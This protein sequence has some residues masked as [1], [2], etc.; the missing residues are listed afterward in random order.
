MKKMGTKRVKLIRL[1]SVFTLGVAL[2]AIAGGVLHLTVPVGPLADN[3]AGLFFLLT[4]GA[5]NLLVYLDDRNIERKDYLGRRLHLL[6]YLCLGFVIA[7][8]LALAGLNML[9]TL[10]YSSRFNRLIYGGIRFIYFGM[11]ILGAILG[12]QNL[13]AIKGGFPFRRRYRISWR[14][15]R[16]TGKKILMVLCY[17]ALISGSAGLYFFLAG[18]RSIFVESAPQVAEVLFSGFALFHAFILPSVSVLFLKLQN[19]PGSAATLL[20][21]ILGV[22]CFILY[23]LPLMALSETC[24]GAEAEFTRAFGSERPEQLNPSWADYFLKSSFSLPA[25]FLGLPPGDYR[26]EKDILFYEGS[27]G[28]DE[29]L[30]L[31]YDVFMPPEGREDLPGWGTALIRIHGGAW[32]GGDKGFANMMQVN[33]YFAAQGYTVFD[34]Q[35]GLTDLVDLTIFQPYLG[36][37]ELTGPYTLD[38]MVRHLGLFTKHLAAH[39]SDYHLDP[40]SVFISGGSAG[41]QLAMALALAASGGQYPEICTDQLKIKGYILTYPAYRTSFLPDLSEDPEWSDLRILVD[42]KSPPCLICQGTSDGLVPSQAAI[43]FREKYIKSGNEQCAVLEILRSGHLGDLY[44]PGYFNQ[45]LIYYMERF[46]ALYR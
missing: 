10:I 2:L 12:W 26:Y 45:V 9:V 8:L 22:T 28:I 32:V 37:D 17:I 5:V 39:A 24:A 25:F 33:K 34:V 30:K 15:S 23:L 1:V 31:Y 40:G 44:F 18:E 6:G 16:Q 46:M 27:S 41:G 11:L 43:Q 20:A 7:G 4:L 35:Y 36:P 3:I 29:G 19:R 38:D 42:E 14:K 13:A 21:G